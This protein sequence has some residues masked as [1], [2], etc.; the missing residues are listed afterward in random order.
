MSEPDNFLSRW[1]RRKQAAAEADPEAT[2]EA[3]ANEHPKSD[4]VKPRNDATEPLFD[5]QSLPPIERITAETDIRAF[6]APGVP[7]DLA[8]A[9]L[10]RAWATDPKIRDF[11]GP[12]DY[13]WDY[14]APGSMRGFGPLEMTEELRRAVARIVGGAHPDNA[15]DSTPERSALPPPPYKNTNESNVSAELPH[16]TETLA[17]D[18]VKESTG[19]I[20]TESDVCDELTPCDKESTA[21]QH[22]PK[23]SVSLGITKFRCHGGALPK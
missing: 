12:A 13:A 16:R 18:G 14:H 6:L 9:A 20:I 2:P 15:P 10:R 5:P 1:S 22:D 3:G 7:A 17:T 8:R 11:V 21:A 23:Q 19:S 4:A